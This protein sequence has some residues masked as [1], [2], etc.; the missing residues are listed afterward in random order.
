MASAAQTALDLHLKYPLTFVAFSRGFT[1][2]HR[3]V[4]IA[5]R[6][7]KGGPN[8]PVFAPADGTVYLAVDGQDNC[9]PWGKPDYGN[10]VMIQHA[11]GVWTLS[12]HLL[13]GSVCV[14][15]GQK[16]KRGQQVALMGNSGYSD[17]PH[18]HFEV[19]LND[20]YDSNRV[21]PVDYVFAWPDQDVW[22]ADEKDYHI[23]RYDPM[24]EVGNPVARNIYIDQMEVLATT[25]RARKEPDLKADV[26]G[27]VKPGI[28]NVYGETEA[29]GYKWYQPEDFWCANDKEGTWIKLLPSEYYGTP[30]P[31]NEKADQIEVTAT[32]L[33]ARHEP[34]LKGEVLGFATPGIYN[35]DAF[36]DN[37]GYRWF[38]AND[39]VNTFW[40]A[41]SPKGD[42]VHYYPKKEIKYDM[43]L[44]QLN[45]KQKDEVEAYCAA[46]GINYIV[47]EA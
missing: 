20:T 32:T 3:G 23:K 18:D 10:Y 6:W 13:K 26:L 2:S 46:E 40:V 4:D 42:W 7:D 22:P 15:K 38:K 19:Y 41:Q 30:V 16:V 34:S 24:K 44:F 31:R 12:G 35:C 45:E 25:L 14:K 39:G 11:P 5:W 9:Y 29:D 28:Y 47:G 33:R 1:K 27:Y 17:G 8:M 37:D 43:S 36:D 21:D